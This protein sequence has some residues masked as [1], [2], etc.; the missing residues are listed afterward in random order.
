MLSG[1][2]S[3]WQNGII[4]FTVMVMP[5]G[6]LGVIGVCG[7]CSAI[8]PFQLGRRSSGAKKELLTW[9]ACPHPDGNCTIARGTSQKSLC[10]A[11]DPLNVG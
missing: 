3:L 8:C 5:P 1:S 6:V 11:S 9:S 10:S 7:L 2:K 4:S